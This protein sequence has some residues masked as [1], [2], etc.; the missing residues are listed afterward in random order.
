TSQ[1]VEQT[2][3]DAA[4][5]FI[6][7]ADHGLPLAGVALAPAAAEQL[8][9]DAAGLMSLGGNHEQTTGLADAGGKPDVGSASG[10]VRGHGYAAGL[11]RLG[12]DFGLGPVLTRIEHAVLDARLVEQAG[13]MLAVRHRTGADKDGATGFM[14]PCYLFRDRLPFRLGRR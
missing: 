14:K 4:Y 11:A 8:T 1:P 13:N 3:E 10:H 7:E 9:I 12:H 6:V 2:A 5:Q